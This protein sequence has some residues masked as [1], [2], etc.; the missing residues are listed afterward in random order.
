V[1]V[2]QCPAWLLSLG[3]IVVKGGVSLL[4]KKACVLVR[5]SVVTVFDCTWACKEAG[6]Q[7]QWQQG[8]AW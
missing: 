6:Q 8:G 4:G 1:V 7:A 3:I 5:E 2:A